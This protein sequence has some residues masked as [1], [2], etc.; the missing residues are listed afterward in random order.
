MSKEINKTNIFSGPLFII[1]MYR[2]GTKLLRILLNQSPRIIIPVVES[3]FI[4][5]LIN[6]FGDSPQ[7]END[8]EFQNFYK[9]LTKTSF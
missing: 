2:S 6:K 3:C 8:N 9:S 4:P 1:G 5:Y 7:F